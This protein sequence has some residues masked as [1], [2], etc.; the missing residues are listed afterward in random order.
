M[1]D[2]GGAGKGDKVRALCAQTL[3]PEPRPLR[4]VGA[5][6]AAAARERIRRRR[7]R[8]MGAELGPVIEARPLDWISIITAYDGSR[9]VASIV[10]PNVLMTTIG[11]LELND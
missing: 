9:L 1:F 2:G 4:V 3:G 7:K 8:G 11:R 6:T 10:P 5:A